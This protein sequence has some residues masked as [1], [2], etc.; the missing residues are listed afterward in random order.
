[1]TGVNARLG[2]ATLVGYRLEQ[3]KSGAHV[4][5]YWRAAQ[6]FENRMQV[7]V[8]LADASGHVLAQN[9]SVPVEGTYPTTAWQVGELIVDAHD[10]KTDAKGAF[11]IFVGMYDPRTNVRVPA[12]D[13]SGA[14]LADDRVALGQITVP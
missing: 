3:V 1:M 7:F 5:L 10:V 9:D 2:A 11:T 4:V 6:S 13:A 14:R 12:F 8:H